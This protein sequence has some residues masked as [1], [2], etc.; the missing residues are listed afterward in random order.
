MEVQ[1]APFNLEA[2]FGFGFLARV[3][4]QSGRLSSRGLWTSR[5]GFILSRFLRTPPQPIVAFSGLVFHWWTGV[6]NQQNKLDATSGFPMRN[7][8]GWASG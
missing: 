4:G 6:V 8:T 5:A 7:S 1:F 2:P 3:P